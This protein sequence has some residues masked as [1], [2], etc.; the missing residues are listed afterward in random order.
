V[1]VKI[2]DVILTF[3]KPKITQIQYQ[4]VI[5]ST[6]EFGHSEVIIVDVDK[7]NKD[8]IVELI[9]KKFAARYRIDEKSIEVK[10]L[11][12]LPAIPK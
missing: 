8:K 5:L 12:E 1:L 10:W 3:V 4:Y 6:D 2:E 9:R 11:V 7:V